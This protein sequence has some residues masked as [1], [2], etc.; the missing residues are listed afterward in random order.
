M[1]SPEA[2]AALAA[3][4]IYHRVAAELASRWFWYLGGG[5]LFATLVTAGIVLF[6]FLKNS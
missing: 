3:R 6:T 4:T 5:L 2:A 1:I